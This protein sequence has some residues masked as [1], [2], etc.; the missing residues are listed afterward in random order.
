ME[1]LSTAFFAARLGHRVTVYE[2]NPKLGGL[3]RSA[4]ARER[5]PE[6]ILDWDIEGILEMG[7]TAETGTVM[8]KDFTVDSLLRSDVEAV[9]LAAGGWDSRMARKTVT[10]IELP[11]PDRRLRNLGRTDPPPARPD[12][13][14]C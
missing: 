2:A 14:F 1:G 13:G 11:L 8:G 10:E 3:L 12:S 4:I 7:V 6:D 5:L 9:F